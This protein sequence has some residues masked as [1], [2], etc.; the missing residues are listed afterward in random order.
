MILKFT[1]FICFIM[2]CWLV[3]WT[4]LVWQ[5][6]H[7][8]LEFFMKLQS[9]GDSEKATDLPDSQRCCWVGDLRDISKI[10]FAFA[11]LVTLSGFFR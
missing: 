8:S 7:S 11:F 1:N 10:L 5:L 9:L 6:C 3:I 2:T 4:D